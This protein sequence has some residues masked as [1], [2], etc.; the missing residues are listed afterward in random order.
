MDA[1]S[2]KTFVWMKLSTV[3][4]D[5]FTYFTVD[6]SGFVGAVIE[7]A[8]SKYDHWRLNAGQVRL[9]LMAKA[10]ESKPLQPAIAQALAGGL[11]PLTEEA[12]LESAGVT[13]EAWLIVVSTLVPPPVVLGS[14]VSKVA[15]SDASSRSVKSLEFAHGKSR[16]AEASV[17]FWKLT[18]AAF[19]GAAL[20]PF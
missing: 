6:L 5:H 2:P 15:S 12:T 13:S 14:G 1:A 8:C 16:E 20:E 10:G 7:R 4:E 19:P 9:F 18:H 3:E 17:A 11:K